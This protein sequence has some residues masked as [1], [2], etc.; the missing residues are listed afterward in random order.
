M[1]KAAAMASKLVQE[2]RQIGRYEILQKRGG[3]GSGTVYKARDPD[4]GDLV[5]IKILKAEMARDPSLL[6]R[7][8]Q[9]F[10]ATRQLRS[11]HIVRALAFG[12]QR[13]VH[14]LV[15]EFVDGQDLWELIS[16]RQRLSESE[17]VGIIGQVAEALDEAHAHGMIHRDVKPD[18]ILLLKDGK[19][20]LTDF[21]LVK[22]LSSELNLTKV[23]DVLG[24]PNFMAPEQF[25]DPTKVDRRA[26]VY[27]LAATLYMAVTREVPFKAKNCLA[28]I[29]KKLMADLVPPR[30]IAPD[31]S[32]RAE[33]A[34]LRALHLDPE[35][36]PASCGAFMQELLGQQ[37]VPATV[38]PAMS[39]ARLEEV[40]VTPTSI[41]RRGATRY[42]ASLAS[43]CRP[44]GGE[45]RTRW[46]SRVTNISATGVGLE[47]SRRFD[48]GAVLMLELWGPRR[49]V[50]SRQLIHVV[51]VTQQANARWLVGCRLACKLQDGEL[52]HL[53]AAAGGATPAFG[54]RRPRPRLGG[55]TA[56]HG[57]YKGG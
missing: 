40:P 30:K 39:V 8:K 57:R 21:G 26:D 55:L 22:D 35:Q 29:Q 56:P 11:P 34:I 31:L 33:Q 47:V 15:M 6:T 13:G 25:D 43:C 51:R 4:T 5:A 24:T 18:N 2:S 9:E 16:S 49:V 52:Q 12:E 3:G 38:R 7:F 10:L 44:I 42:P 45:R 46:K 48:R 36:R 1:R 41:E 20:K 27:A 32:E 54:T 17:A 53:Q 23:A 19:A 14:F 50:V 37:K 28:T